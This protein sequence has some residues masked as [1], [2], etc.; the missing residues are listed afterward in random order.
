MVRI[1]RGFASNKAKTAVNAERR[2]GFA[3][4]GKLR[5]PK[6]SMV[7]VALVISG[8]SS[9]NGR[10]VVASGEQAPLSTQ[11]LDGEVQ[12]SSPN[13]V[14]CGSNSRSF[15]GCRV[16]VVSRIGWGG[17]R[18]NTSTC[19]GLESESQFRISLVACCGRKGRVGVER[20][21][22]TLG[23]VSFNGPSLWNEGLRIV[24]LIMG[25]R[26]CCWCND[27]D[28]RWYGNRKPL[29][30]AGLSKNG[31]AGANACESDE[32]RH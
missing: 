32:C 30:S 11:E 6:T 5:Y 14:R 20:H 7:D 8:D 13:V 15:L 19:R 21:V 29:S 25:E 2:R 22:H 31:A 17:D 9:G 24:R 1:C 12:I 23:H 26:R 27:T 16:R 4:F 18:P 3:V 10:G 28:A